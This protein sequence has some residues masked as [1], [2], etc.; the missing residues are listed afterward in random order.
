MKAFQFRFESVLDQRKRDE[1][2]QQERMS[3]KVAELNKVV[4]GLTQIRESLSAFQARKNEYMV[5]SELL[6]LYVNQT[7]SNRV[8]EKLYEDERLKAETALAED[9]AVLLGIVRK[10]KALEI[11]LEKDLALYKV[12]KAK[13]ERIELEEIS[14][15]KKA[16]ESQYVSQLGSSNQ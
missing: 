1:E 16:I 2:K 12:K 6:S 3:P 8:A 7:S 13:R 4:G 9:R 14:A 5:S 15:T 10:R 11:L